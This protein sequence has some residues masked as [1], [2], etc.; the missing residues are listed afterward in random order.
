MSI[1]T[2]FVVPPLLVAFAMLAYL[3]WR[4]QSRRNLIDLRYL[5]MV[6]AVLMMFTQILLAGSFPLVSLVCFPLA[7]AWLAVASLL[8]ARQMTQG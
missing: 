1:P 8:L 3:H 4:G 6:G 2:Y 5:M 7:L